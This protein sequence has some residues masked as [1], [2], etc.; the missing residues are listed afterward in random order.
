MSQRTRVIGL[1]GGVASGKSLVAERFAQLGAAVID[2]DQ[3]GHQVLRQDEVRERVRQRWG[4]AVFDQDGHVDRRR[5]AAIVFGSSPA[6]HHELHYLQQITH[7]RIGAA[8]RD[9]VYRLRQL[10]APAVVLD[11]AVMLEAGWDDGCDQIVFV[12][13]PPDLRR[14]RVRARGWTDAMLEAREAAQM[15]LDQKRNS[16]SAVIDNSGT[17]EATRHQVDHLW[18]T[19]VERSLDTPG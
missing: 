7:G 17:P 2:A 3:I 16:A 10:G 11:A 13:A 6:G 4:D 14:Q 9:E 12:D 15:P 5:L 18:R 1:V 8:I 19:W